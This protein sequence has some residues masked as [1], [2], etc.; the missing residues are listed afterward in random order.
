MREARAYND[1]PRSPRSHADSLVRAEQVGKQLFPT[2]YTPSLQAADPIIIVPVV[3]PDSTEYHRAKAEEYKNEVDRKSGYINNLND[4]SLLELPVGISPQNGSLNYTIIISEVKV[5][6]AGAFLEAY[7]VFELPQTGDKIAFRGKNIRFSHEGGLIGDGRLELIGSYNIKLS[8]K[9]LLSILGKGN[10]YVE[11]DCKG[12]K[13]IGI[14]AGIEF[15]RDLVVPEDESG[16]PKPSPERLQIK[17]ATHAQSWSDLM[18]GVTIPSFQVAGLNGVGFSVTDAYLDFSDLAN[19][20]GMDFPKGYNTSFL[21]AGKPDLWQGFYLKR[22]DIKL[23]PS[24]SKRDDN[25]RITLGVEDMI[26]DDQGFT[27]SV[28]GENL[29]EA[30][31]MDGWSYSLDRLS[32]DLITNQVKGFDLSG[33]LTVP[34]LKGK[35]GKTS[36]FGYVAQRTAEGNYIFTVKVVDQLRMDLWAA[37]VKLFA[38]SSVTV[39]EKNDKFY[40][41]ANLNGELTIAIAGGS[42]PATNFNSIRFE[43]LVISSQAPKFKVGTLGFGSE[44]QSSK[45][46]GFPLVISK[47]YVQS[48]NDN[49]GLGFDLT[50]NIGG[51]PKE[52]GF[53]GTA[54][55][56][57]WGK[58]SPSVTKVGEKKVTTIED[59]WTFDRVDLTG[60]KVR[61]VKPGV[62]ELAGEINFFNRDLIYGDGFKGSL[63][64]KIQTIKLSAEALFGKTPKFRYWYA[65][66]LVE[67]RTGIVMAPGIS[68]YGFGGGFYSNMKQ[69]TEGKGSAKGKT[70]SGITYIP[71]E[72][73]TGIKALVMLGTAGKPEPFN[74]DVSLEVV[75]NNHGGINS[76]TLTGNAR[77]MTPPLGPMADKI[78]ELVP[79]A[80][81]GSTVKNLSATA[82]GQIYGSIVLKFDNVNDVFHGDIE[83]FASVAGGLVKGIGDNNRAGW[84]TIHFSEDEWYILVGT[85]DDPLGLEVAKLF[86]S[87]SYFMMGE[88][89]PG[90]PPPP[91][92]VSEILGNIDLD[93]ARDL[94]QLSSGLGF[95]FGLHFGV[96]TGDLRFL[97]FYGRFSAGVGVDFMLKNY[98]TSAH[99]E[100]SSEPIGINGW[101]AN[102]QAYGFVQGKI[103]IKVNLKFYKGDYDILNIGAAAI[104]QARGPN[105]FYMHGAVGGYYKI[106]GGL[107]KGQCKFDVTIG[108]NCKVVRDGAPLGDV[109]II[110][111]VTPSAGEENIDVFNAPQAAFNIPIGEEFEITDINDAKKFFRGN[112]KQFSVKDGAQNIAGNI[113]WNA[114]NDVAVFDAHDILPPK[115]KLTVVVNV[116]FEERVNGQW[117]V[118][119]VDGKPAEEIVESTFTTGDAPDYIPLTNVASSYPVVGQYNFHPKEYNKGFIELKRGQPYLFT[120]DAKW[121]QKLRVTNSSSTDDYL[122]TSFTYNTGEK[123]VLFDVPAGFKE[124]KGYQLEIMNFPAQK[125][126]LDENVK[127]VSTTVTSADKS[128]ETTISTKSVTGTVELRDVKSIF[129]SYFRTSKYPTFQSKM[130]ALSLTKA[131]SGNNG[132]NILIVGAYWQGDEFFD[133][134]EIGTANEVSNR[135]IELEANLSGNTWYEKSVYPLVYDAYPL[136]GQFTVQSR[137][138][139]TLGL[140]P[141]KDVYLLQANNTLALTSSSIPDPQSFFSSSRI[142]YHLMESMFLD[143]YDLQRQVANYAVNGTSTPRLNLLLVNPFPIIDYGMY[144]VRLTYRIPGANVNTSSADVELK[145]LR[146]DK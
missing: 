100:G 137:N 43:Q 14:E 48:K 120:P 62:V 20:T 65:D 121:V 97:M 116:T 139:A 66:A 88:N 2:L 130:K 67:I 3:N 111:Q 42:G 105:P 101:Y 32:I 36:R 146:N 21:A 49:V 57:V 142:E 80:V 45:A 98:G 140:P 59:D 30:G 118:V 136:Q 128:V 134:F 144:K 96:D 12:F 28:F 38:G 73:T 5:T 90:S 123:K 18:L 61:I 124:A 39:T 119:T 27:G 106:L 131:L 33:K 81:G 15:S 76:V 138:V 41:S 37:D 110:A 64:G 109:K 92:Q 71:D 51:S 56:I 94:N 29:L 63:S 54:S 91:A 141:V 55:L 52:E 89:L 79:A 104:L 78:K 87:R 125:A 1:H 82:S 68:A 16:K 84:A 132:N 60:V 93:N 53:S 34:M 99:C 145:Y 7:F 6:S 4:L 19:P 143:Y 35:D 122:E 17:F 47:I 11:F 10:T 95:A 25:S 114:A 77:F 46:A 58:Q 129:T 40:P 50:I 69:D 22:V 108:E 107:V 26:L 75:L 113:K 126:V 74:G 72:N 70:K 133:A 85:P 9:M 23:P 13:G 8:D 31:D 115:K 135:M 102:G 117:K 127:T 112:V 103:G 83:I 44:G 86:K 24:F